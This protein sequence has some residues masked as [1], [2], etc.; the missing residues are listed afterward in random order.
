MHLRCANRNVL[1]VGSVL[2]L[3]GLCSPRGVP[4]RLERNV[5]S[6]NEQRAQPLTD[7]TRRS[8]FTT[9]TG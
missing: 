4:V 8:I 9:L 6:L 3:A 2:L 7:S 5:Q 1:V